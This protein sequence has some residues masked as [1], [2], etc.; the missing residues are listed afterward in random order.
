MNESRLKV[1]GERKRTFNAP[2]FTM[3]ESIKAVIVATAATVVEW[4]AEFSLGVVIVQEMVVRAVAV[5][6]RLMANRVNET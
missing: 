2:S 1:N 5:V 3:F 4:L 6:A